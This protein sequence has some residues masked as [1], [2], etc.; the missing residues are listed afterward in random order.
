M[1][2]GFCQSKL[3]RKYTTERMNERQHIDSGW[4]FQCIDF[5]LV[6]MPRRYGI[7]SAGYRIGCNVSLRNN[8]L[9]FIFLHCLLTFS[10]IYCDR[11]TIVHCILPQSAK[12]CR[13]HSMYIFFL[14]LPLLSLRLIDLISSREGFFSSRFVFNGTKWIPRW[15]AISWLFIVST[16]RVAHNT[17]IHNV[18]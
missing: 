14:C 3:I 11:A 13:W 17:H 5:F 6:L 1:H 16:W 12:S 7:L 9:N 10:L 15:V 8:I 2:L 4:V 18:I